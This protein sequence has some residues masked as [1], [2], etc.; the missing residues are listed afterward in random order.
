ML[1]KCARLI[2]FLPSCWKCWKV[3]VEMTR[4]VCTY[5]SEARF[6]CDQFRW[7]PDEFNI[8]LCVVIDTSYF[9][10]SYTL[11]WTWSSRHHPPVFPPRHQGHGGSR[12]PAPKGE[13][14]SPPQTAFSLCLSWQQFEWTRSF[15]PF[16]PRHGRNGRRWGSPT[17]ILS[18][19][20]VANIA[21]KCV[22]VSEQ[23]LHQYCTYVGMPLAF[24]VETW[25][26]G[27]LWTILGQ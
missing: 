24:P 23:W 3:R 9:L 16:S 21:A 11:H 22:Q 17:A 18:Q 26:M 8:C 20:N 13:R 1:M 15:Q 14:V 27:N 7:N 2:N 12:K 5:V 6:C 10:T 4:Y 25:E 19:L